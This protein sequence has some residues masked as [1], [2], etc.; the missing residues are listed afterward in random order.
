MQVIHG[1]SKPIYYCDERYKKLVNVVFPSI[2]IPFL[3]AENAFIFTLFQLIKLML[4]LLNSQ[5]KYNFIY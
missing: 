1:V 5:F 3:S 2:L 4:L